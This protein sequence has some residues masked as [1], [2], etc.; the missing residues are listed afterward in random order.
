MDF[1][2]KHDINVVLHDESRQLRSTR[3]NAIGAPSD[4]PQGSSDLGGGEGRVQREIGKLTL[5]E[6]RY[7]E[8]T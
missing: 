6:L 2:E 7:Q 3:G 4:D 1:G 8:Q 5:A